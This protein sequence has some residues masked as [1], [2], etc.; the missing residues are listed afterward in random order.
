MNFLL[1][2][3]VISELTKTKP[4]STVI[5]WLR[6]QHEEHLFLSS[7]TIGEIQKG[8]T[9]LNP[10]SAKKAKLQI[11]LDVDLVIRFG[12]RIIGVDV[13]VARKWG[14]IQAATENNGVRLPVVDGLIAAIGL[15]YDM[16][17]VTR[18]IQD[19]RASGVNLYN[20]WE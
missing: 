9:K 18:N 10:N 20:P 7:I 11:W 19:M 5:T 14:E 6:T 8:I 12:K 4:N 15:A 3:C 1:D 16:T 2:T 13:P 17:V